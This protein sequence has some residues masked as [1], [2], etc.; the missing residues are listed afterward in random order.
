MRCYANMRK[1]R[2]RAFTRAPVY[3]PRLACESAR[4]C[5]VAPVPSLLSTCRKP[6]ASLLM[7]VKG[8]MHDAELIGCESGCE[9]GCE[10]SCVEP[11]GAHRLGRR[12]S[13]CHS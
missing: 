11:M 1:R 3:G 12:P 10:R 6:H 4:V 9:S 13:R 5:V 8:E 2:V 7:L